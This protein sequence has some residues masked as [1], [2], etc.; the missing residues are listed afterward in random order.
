MSSTSRLRARATK[1]SS[2]NPMLPNVSRCRRSGERLNC[3]PKFPANPD[4]T[5]GVPGRFGLNGLPSERSEKEIAALPDS[6]AYAPVPLW[7]LSTTNL[8]IEPSTPARYGDIHG[9]RPR[10][11]K[12]RFAPHIRSLYGLSKEEM[13]LKCQGAFEVGVCSR[14]MHLTSKRG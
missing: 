12:K 7:D 2:E 5:Y 10:S 6:A 3:A 8:T 14:G 11:C 4:V 1:R 13:Q 9:L